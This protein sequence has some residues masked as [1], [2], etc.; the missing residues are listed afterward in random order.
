MARIIQTG[1]LRR[2]TSLSANEAEWIYN[3]LDTCV[4]LEVLREIAPQLDNTT[5]HTY[6]FS[7]A[8]QGP[9]LEMTVRGIKVDQTRRKHVLEDVRGAIERLGDNLDYIIRE[10]IGTEASWRSSAQLANLLYDV[11]GLPPVKK[12][13]AHGAYV[14]TVDR[15]ALEKLSNYYLAEPIVVHL[16][17]LR[18]LDKKRQLLETGIDRDGRMRTNFNI[19]GTNTGRFASAI[20]D[21]GTGTNLQNIDRE[22]RSIFVAD[23]GYKFLNLDLEQADARNVGAICWNHFVASHGEAF[24][25]AYLDACEGG[26]LHTEVC[27][28]AWQY[29]EWGTEPAGFRRVADQIAYRS[30]SYRDLAK[31]L[32]HGTNYYGL[33]PT[34]ARHTKVER[35]LIE[36]FQRNYFR[37]YPAIGSVDKNDHTSDHWHNRVRHQLRD[38]G[39]ITTLLGR[40]RGFFGRWNDDETLRGAIAFE[41]QSLTADEINTGIINLFRASKLELLV[42]VHDSILTQIPENQESEL[43]PWALDALKCPIELAG[44]RPFVVPTEAKVGWNWADCSDSNPDGL[45]KWKGG[46]TRSREEMPKSLSIDDL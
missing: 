10:G 37:A 43:V 15:E 29:L 34:M 41:P 44:G 32:G 38:V 46:D 7:K 45:I 27:R 19:A 3:G 9:V 22:L 25:G 18:D 21:F 6:E 23:P 1:N 39:S 17:A 11:M 16:L 28:M 24:A 40:R 36:E 8:L 42:Q 5:R 12:R 2:D 14:R 4:T 35:P 26:D 13:N 33:P 30:L 31:K 20:S